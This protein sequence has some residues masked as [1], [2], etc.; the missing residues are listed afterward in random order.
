M[1]RPDAEFLRNYYASFTEAYENQCN[2]IFYGIIFL[3]FSVILNVCLLVIIIY[4]K[5]FK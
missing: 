4:L 2:T 3:S 1:K 5:F